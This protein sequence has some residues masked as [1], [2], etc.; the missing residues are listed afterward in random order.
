MLLP[1]IYFEKNY[2]DLSSLIEKG[3]AQEY[4][5]KAKE[6][7]IRNVFIKRPI[8]SQID[9]ETYFDMITPYGYGGP[10]I[11]ESTGDRQDLVRGFKEAFNQYC[12]EEKIVSGFFRFHPILENALDFMDDFNVEKIRQT[13]ATRLEDSDPFTK[14]FSKST[15][16]LI[17]KLLADENFSYKIYNRPANLDNFMEIYENTMD[18]NQ[19]GD[20]YYFGRTYFERLSELFYEETYVIDVFYDSQCIS[21]GIYFIYGDFL[22]AHL[23]GTLDEYLWLSPAYY[24]KYLT[25]ELAQLKGC[26]YIHYGG[27][28]TN[29]EEDGLLKFKK[30]FTRTGIFDYYIAKEVFIPE[31]NEK[32]IE[33]TGTKDSDF[34]PKY[35]GL[36]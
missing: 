3:Q 32:L 19:A 2:A 17:R 12:R 13:V 20:F 6:G 34:F 11:L 10:L 30:K 9:G 36:L 7:I 18:R 28:T 15:R 25:L 8:D 24:L 5:Y 22:H 31:I 33:E 35:R 29:S 16:K 23:S 26:K 1:D 21:S 14:E 27:G 4:T